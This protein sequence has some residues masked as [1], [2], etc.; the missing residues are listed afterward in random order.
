MS[1]SAATVARSAGSTLHVTARSFSEGAR[2]AFTGAVSPTLTLT[3]VSASSMPAS[4]EMVRT[5]IWALA[6]RVGWDASVAVIVASPAARV[7]TSPFS[8][9]VATAS[10]EDVHTRSVTFAFVGSKVVLSATVS[11]ATTSEVCGVSD[12]EVI[13]IVRKRITWRAW[14]LPQSHAKR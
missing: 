4:S 9:T 1:A 7:R 8:F 6:D 12:R 14:F 2:Y 3:W 5:R 13:G 10:F 11:P